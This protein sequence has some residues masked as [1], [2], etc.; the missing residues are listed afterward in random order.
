[1]REIDQRRDAARL[2]A[3]APVLQLAEQ[4]LFGG[5]GAIPQRGQLV[6]H[7]DGGGERA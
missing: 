6:A 5:C 2:G 7:G 4:L 1:M 3:M